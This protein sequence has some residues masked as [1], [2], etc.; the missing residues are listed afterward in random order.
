[1]RIRLALA[2]GVVALLGGGVGFF[3][4]SPRKEPVLR[5]VHETIDLSSVF[6]V[7]GE[8]LELQT[9]LRNHSKAGI[10]VTELSKSCP[11]MLADAEAGNLPFPTILKA[12][13]ELP[14]RLRINTAGRMGRQ[15]FYLEAQGRREGG[16]ELPACKL[17]VLANLRSAV[18]PI[19]TEFFTSVG[20][21]EPV[22]ATLTLADDWPGDGV[23][24]KEIKCTAADRFKI[25]VR[26]ATGTVQR[27][28]LT[29]TKRH[30]VEIKYTPAKGAKDFAET[31]SVLATD[32]RAGTLDVPFHGRVESPYEFLPE[33][34]TIYGV[35]GEPFQRQVL[36][37]AANARYAEIMALE[38]PFGFLVKC[39]SQGASG[40]QLLTV[41]GSFP[42]T[43]AN[44][45]AVIRFQLGHIEAVVEL[46]INVVPRAKSD[47]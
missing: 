25:T 16:S 41:S 4:G 18:L 29:L 21:D 27:H 45:Q 14:I 39:E 46:P 26:S 3:V 24:V 34:L 1:M 20:A 2:I 6:Y 30:E 42:K 37:R 47:G 32:Q 7:S 35:P 9:G 17:T 13:D 38:T 28:G 31:I 10:E 11:C 40:E 5:F 44:T 23:T 19:P 33:S 8:I 12:G 22:S 15:A 43:T 36:Y